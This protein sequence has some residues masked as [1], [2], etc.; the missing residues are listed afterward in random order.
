MEPRLW[1]MMLETRLSCP[2]GADINWRHIPQSRLK[3][4]DSQLLNCPSA[5]RALLWS[6]GDREVQ[7]LRRIGP[8]QWVSPFCLFGRPDR[9]R[10]CPN[11]GTATRTRRHAGVGAG[12]NQNGWTSRLCPDR[13]GSVRL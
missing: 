3:D 5:A 10:A 8:R 12:M 1:T 9:G 2:S 13:N 11:R 7:W 6:G 4:L